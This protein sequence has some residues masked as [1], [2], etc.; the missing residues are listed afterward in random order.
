[1]RGLSIGGVELSSP[2]VL[3]PLAG[4]TDV[5]MRLLAQQQGASL[6]YTEMISV[7]GLIY[8]DKK[9]ES[10]MHIDEAEGPVGI[11][12]F[13]REPD[14]FKE[15]II[16]SSD[17]TNALWDINMGCPVPKVV[18][19]GEGSALMKEPLRAGK[20]VEACV[21]ATDKPVTVKMRTG[22]DAD[23]INV[24]EVA[25]TVE[26]AGAGAVAVHGR[27]RKQ[28]YQGEAD[29]E[30]IGRIKEALNIPVI[31]NG[32]VFTADD[33]IRMI[34]ETGVDAVM[35]ARGALGN[36]WIFRELNA[37]YDGDNVPDKPTLSE[38]K[39]AMITH[40]DGIADLKGENRAVAEF[41]KHAGWY[42]RGIRGA[43]AFRRRVNEINE[44]D[45]LKKAI[46]EI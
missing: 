28:M 33:G 34:D 43:A 8:G 26:A 30:I 1:M 5:P 35:V 41:R 17:R 2:F 13:G 21:S 6:C 4:I 15:A 39:D 29:W 20:I 31:G 16:K 40:V 7:K 11:Q 37:M 46:E 25:K 10:L 24:V 12:L 18:K 36:P 44:L 42:V 45:E 38:I 22:W 14:E 23:S 3:A 27:T 32:D 19:N 9:T